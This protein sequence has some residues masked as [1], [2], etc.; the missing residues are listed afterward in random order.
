MRD[1]AASPPMPMNTTPTALLALPDIPAAA[2]LRAGLLAMP[3]TPTAL[4]AP[5]DAPLAR[6]ARLAD[7]PRTVAF[8]DI[9]AFG[10][11]AAPTLPALDAALPRDDSRGRVHLARLR[12]GHVGDGDRRWVRALGF[13]GL[14][15]GFDA[16]ACEATL[17]EVLDAVALA[18]GLAPIAPA[19]LTLYAH[20]L[21]DAHDDASPRALIRRHAGMSAEALAARLLQRLD[22]GRRHWRMQAWA[23]SFVGEEAVPRMVR[24]LGCSREEAV[25]VGQALRQLGLLVHVAHEHP[26]LD[27]HFFYR[28]AWSA[29]VDELPLGTLLA[30]MQAPDGLALADRSDLARVYPACWVGHEAV[31]W[32][33][34]RHRLDRVDAWLVL[35]RLMQFG[36]VEHVVHARPFIDGPFFYRF[37]GMP[38]D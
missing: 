15:A 10:P 35:H 25:A 7:E 33:V 13:A 21:A 22:I 32:L 34:A 1:G 19:D 18:L 6:L 14:W 29:R 12:G 3:V 23:R 2:A 5:G 11:P 36:L 26:F 27:D 20:V 38:P 24:E 9:S 31:D 37:T 30:Q 17:R 16:R 4:G 28:L 8:V